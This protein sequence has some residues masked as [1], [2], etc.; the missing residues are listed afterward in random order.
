[1]IGELA[2]IL[3]KILRAPFGAAPALP[4][5]SIKT[6]GRLALPGARKNSTFT[7]CSVAGRVISLPA[8]SAADAAGTKLESNSSARGAN[9]ERVKAFMFL[10]RFQLGA[11]KPAGW[12]APYGK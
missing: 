11:R 8:I 4:P 6:V 7:G 10:I 2:A 9:N 12:E 1:V 5:W 3:A